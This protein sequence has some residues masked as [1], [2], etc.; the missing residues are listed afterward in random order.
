MAL[1]LY[2]VART[3]SIISG[4]RLT[5][6]FGVRVHHLHT[7][8]ALVH[9]LHLGVEGDASAADRALESSGELVH[10]ADGMEHRCRRR[11]IARRNRSQPAAETRLQQGAE[12]VGGARSTVREGFVAVIGRIEIA[13]CDEKADQPL[14]VLSRQREI[15][16][17]L[18]DRLDEQ[19][20]DASD[21]VGLDLAQPQP[22]ICQRACGASLVVEIRAVRL[23]QENL[24]R[25]AELLA[26]V[27]HAGV[28]VRN[29]PGADVDVL[30]LVK[31]ADLA[32]TADLGVL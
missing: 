17:P 9:A 15:Q 7:R 28:R 30:P 4:D 12:V 23:V 21:Q 6:A 29:A 24:Q 27:Q 18:I 20:V 16:L 3:A 13:L 31:G 2:V 32:F 1:L 10:A 26:V 19:L 14:L 5:S 25:N 11:A 22:G 8:V